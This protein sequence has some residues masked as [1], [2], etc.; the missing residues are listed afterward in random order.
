M[1]LIGTV[2]ELLNPR[3]PGERI[4]KRSTVSDQIALSTMTSSLSQNGHVNTEET[5]EFLNGVN[6]NDDKEE[7]AHRKETRRKKSKS[8]IN[9]YIWQT[10]P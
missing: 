6:N 8:N 1:I 7:M 9:F 4:K 5:T 3:K 2:L 10:K